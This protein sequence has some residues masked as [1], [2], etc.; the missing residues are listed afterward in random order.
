MMGKSDYLNLNESIEV[1]GKKVL[2]AQY[3]KLSKEELIALL[4]LQAD[5]ED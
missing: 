2:E 1:I 4:I 5:I 3:S